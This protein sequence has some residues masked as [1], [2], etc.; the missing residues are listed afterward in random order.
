MLCLA[1]GEGGKVLECMYSHWGS[2]CLELLLNSLKFD[3]RQSC[4]FTYWHAHTQ[5]ESDWELSKSVISSHLFSNEL[6]PQELAGFKHVGD[7]V[8][9]TETFVF[10]LVLLLNRDK[11]RMGRR[12]RKKMWER[13]KGED[14]MK[15]KEKVIHIV[16]HC[17]LCGLIYPLQMQTYQKDAH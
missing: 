3:W 8:E 1:T 7:V 15:R 4:W 9:R 16:K 14:K 13:K 2:S 11:G 5:Q 17:E 6:L 12:V 10:V